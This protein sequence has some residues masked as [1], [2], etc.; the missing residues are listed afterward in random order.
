MITAHHAAF[1]VWAV[2]TSIVCV[3][4]CRLRDTPRGQR[5]DRRVGV[6]LV[7]AYV[8]V[9]AWWFA[10][11]NFVWNNTLPIQLC[12]LAALCAPL[13]LLTRRRACRTLLYFWG[14][15]LSTQGFVTPTVDPDP[16]LGHFWMHWINH[17][18]VIGAATYDLIVRRY[19]PTWRDWRLA[20]V[21]SLLYL[22]LIFVLD[23]STGWNYAYVGNT[24][25]EQKTIIDVLG[26]WPLRVVWI[27]LIASAAMTA[28]MI[29]WELARRLKLR[30]T[31]R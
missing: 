12:D 11:A 9:N 17:G 23:V 27:A 13:A 1:F 2:L 31:S 8:I 14:F 21:T 4:G 22:A 5:F 25:P 6:V 18:A 20:M 30:D 19:R 7:L 24:K 26:K 16:S 15:G 3:V 28:L 10:P 29:P